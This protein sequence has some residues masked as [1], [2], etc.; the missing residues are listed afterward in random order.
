MH[1]L[2]K[3]DGL[4]VASLAGLNA[5]FSILD[6]G[7]EVFDKHLKNIIVGVGAC[8]SFYLFLDV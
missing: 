1:F 4:S 6:S 2:L 5:Y 7:C 8:D 3:Q